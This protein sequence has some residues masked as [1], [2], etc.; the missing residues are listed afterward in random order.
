MKKGDKVVCK[1]DSYTSSH[2][3]EIVH[4][5]GTLYTI[6]TTYCT[7]NFN[8]KTLEIETVYRIFLYS[9]NNS[10]NI[11]SYGYHLDGYNCGRWKKFSTYFMSEKELRKEKIKK[12]NEIYSDR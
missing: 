3:G 8:E 7:D 11:N 1:K 2:G 9:E 5:K 4:K 12:I 10:S 6:D